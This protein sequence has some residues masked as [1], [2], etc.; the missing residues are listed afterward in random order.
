MGNEAQQ[1]CS[2]ETD[3][4]LGL[5]PEV[6]QRW[7]DKTNK[8]DTWRRSTGKRVRQRRMETPEISGK[9]GNVKRNIRVK[10]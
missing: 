1:R 4:L 6:I 9:I 5:C 7:E 10:E 8:R 2:R 3:A